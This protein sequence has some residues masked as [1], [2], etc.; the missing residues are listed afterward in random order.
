MFSILSY[1]SSVHKLQPRPA[2]LMRVVSLAK[3]VLQECW[4]H[5][6][7]QLQ[8]AVARIFT[9][10]SWMLVGFVIESCLLSWLNHLLGRCEVSTRRIWFSLAICT[11]MAYS[12]FTDFLGFVLHRITCWLEVYS[13]VGKGAF[14]TFEPSISP[15]LLRTVS[16]GPTTSLLLFV[17]TERL[18]LRFLGNVNNGV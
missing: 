5:A 1:R 17:F 16:R 9:N 18:L 11:S 6:Y 15:A 4:L 13:H 8:V 2:S 12:A 10:T 7:L 3:K 14:V